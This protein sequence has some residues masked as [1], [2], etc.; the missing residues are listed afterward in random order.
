MTANRKLPAAAVLVALL[1]AGCGDGRPKLYPVSGQVFVAGKPADGA[2]VVLHAVGG[3]IPDVPRPVAT[4]GPDGSFQLTTY[5]ANDGAPAG[6]YKVTVMWFPKKKSPME[7]D[8]PDRL[9]GRYASP[10][11]TPL[12]VT[13]Q[14]GPT[15]LEP[16]KLD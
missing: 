8:G 5:D 9:K 2:V 1:A 4:V 12:E 14:P 15:T 16:F 3:G 10:E 6:T 7:P 11:K 13:V